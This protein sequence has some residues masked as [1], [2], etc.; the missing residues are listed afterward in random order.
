[1]FFFDMHFS[2]IQFQRIMPTGPVSQ[3]PVPSQLPNH[4]QCSPSTS[5]QWHSGNSPYRYELVTLNNR[6]KKCYGCAQNFA[7]CYRKAPKNVVVR[8]YDKRV[9]GKDQQGNLVYTE[10]FQAAYYHLNPSHIL[11]KNS[12]F[13][14]RVM[15]ARE[16]WESFSEE[17]KVNIQ[18]SGLHVQV[19]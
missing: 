15:V 19:M 6:V 2:Y 5:K 7:E 10:G 1:M 11:M 17:T 8:H 9:K 12:M 14:G 18:S 16:L 3:P 13:D 4:Q